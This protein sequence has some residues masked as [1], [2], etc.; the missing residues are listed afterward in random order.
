MN[1]DKILRTVYEMAYKA[2]RLDGRFSRR[3]YAPQNTIDSVL[4]AELKKALKKK[5]KSKKKSKKSKKS[6]SE[7]VQ[8]GSP[9]HH[10]FG[11]ALI[12]EDISN[13]TA[14]DREQL[15]DHLGV[16][17]EN[18]FVICKRTMEV[19]RTQPSDDPYFKLYMKLDNGICFI[20]GCKLY[21]FENNQLVEQTTF[22]GDKNA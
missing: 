16:H 6:Y 15:T 13:L 4:N 7:R 19:Y 14:E 3:S 17:I 21:Y 1:I 10:D 20:A 5:L 12:V 11:N 22:K 18:K 9:L 8:V 2:G